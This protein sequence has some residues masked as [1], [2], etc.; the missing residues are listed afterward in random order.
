MKK[1]KI[2]KKDPPKPP[3]K[4]TVT[5]KKDEDIINFSDDEDGFGDMTWDGSEAPIV[6]DKEEEAKRAAEAE[7]K[8]RRDLARHSRAICMLSNFT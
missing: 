2:V 5:K 7:R 3:P 4:K 1:K 8:V 6:V